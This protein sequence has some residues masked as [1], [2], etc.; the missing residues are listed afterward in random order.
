MASSYYYNKLAQLTGDPELHFDLN[1][2]PEWA[3][4]IVGR[5]EFEL[6]LSLANKGD[7]ND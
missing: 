3:I 2:P 4:P 7:M 6:L 5:E 1:I